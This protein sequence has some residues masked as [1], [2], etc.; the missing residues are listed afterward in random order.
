MNVNKVPL[1]LIFSLIVLW[2]C[3]RPERALAGHPAQMTE[4][5]AVVTQLKGTL[6]T[7]QRG[8]L[9]LWST[10]GKQVEKL[11]S[12]IITNGR[13]AFHPRTYEP[14]IYMLGTSEN[15]MCP[16]ILSS[17][18]PVVELGF[19]TGKLE[20][21]GY[22]VQ[23]KENEGWL[24]YMNKEAALMRAIKDAQA[25]LRKATDNKSALEEQV[26]QREKDLWNYQE[27]MIAKYA[28][29]HF[30]KLVRWKQEPYKNDFAKY[31]DNIDF[32]DESIIHSRVLTD[33]IESF[34]RTHS[35]GEQSG[36]IQCVDAV[37]AK[38]K[39][40]DQ[41]LEFALSQM[42]TGFY[43][44]GLENIC[45]YIVDHYIHGDACGDADMSEAIKN[46]AASIGQLAIGKTPPNIQ[47]QAHNGEWVDLYQ[48]ASTHQY[49]L[50]MF[51]SSW[52]EHCKAEAPQVQNLY[53]IWKPKGFEILGVSIDQQPQA[54]LAAIEERNFRFPNV[55]GMN[56][57]KSKV[58]QDYR[59]TRTP[60][61]FLLNDKKEIVL[62]PKNIKEVQTFLTE[63]LK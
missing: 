7:P 13:F 22:A 29:T 17:Q 45:A 58:A 15:N 9:Y 18:E 61:Y 50:V 28:A 52:C 51:W 48:L 40:N 25:A 12:T 37:A 5:Q 57:Y 41:V 47:M 10:Y 53:R 1:L 59:I 33:R 20:N 36:F 32:K 60:T 31:W 30:A 44:S 38:A 55:C 46:T 43:E 2:A 56:Q 54:W 4:T 11:D 3:N 42:L 63:K 8:P 27:E 14:G 49:T 39:V 35:R 34:M 6:T 19:R 23:S 21:S 16:I 26:A 24:T 62:K